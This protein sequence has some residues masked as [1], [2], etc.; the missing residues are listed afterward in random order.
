MDFL[1]PGNLL[2]NTL[3]DWMMAIGVAIG[4]T[5]AMY[6]V[7]TFALRRM[8]E[9]S[10]RTAGKLDDFV[11][12]MLAKTY[13]VF[14]LAIGIYLGSMF[15]VL[16]DNYRL[17]VSRIAVAALIL[18]LGIWGDSGLR[19]W[20]AQVMCA[21]GDGARTAASTIMCAPQRCSSRM[22]ASCRSGPN[23]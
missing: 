7:R 19:A 1:V 11:T 17:I 20:R 4:G 23:G 3:Q 18:Q 2:G 5:I 15:L 6:V 16:P 14:L 21:N 8:H 10:R 13:L 22:K 9:L 12:K